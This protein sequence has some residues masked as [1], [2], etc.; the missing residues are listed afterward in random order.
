[1]NQ[2]CEYPLEILLLIL[3]LN[4]IMLISCLPCKY[5]GIDQIRPV[6]VDFH[7][8]K[9]EKE[10]KGGKSGFFQQEIRSV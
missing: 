1:M 9:K 6:Y 7:G 5:G 2:L 8:P 10:K 4:V 3:L